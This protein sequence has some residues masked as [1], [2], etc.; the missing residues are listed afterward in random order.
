VPRAQKAPPAD[1]TNDSLS[2]ALVPRASWE[3][4]CEEKTQYRRQAE[5]KGKRMLWLATSARDPRRPSSREALSATLGVKL[6]CYN[7][8]TEARRIAVRTR[9]RVCAFQRGGRLMGLLLPMVGGVNNV[10]KSAG[11]AHAHAALGAG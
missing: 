5:A 4:V 9:R 7:K 6:A 1:A 11:A 2:A 10:S 3:V 8:Q